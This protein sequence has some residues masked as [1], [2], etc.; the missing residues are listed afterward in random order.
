MS[1]TATAAVEV[2]CDPATAFAVFTADIASWWKRGTRYWN[3][4]ERARELRFEPGVGGRLIEV[5]DVATG[6]GFEIGRVLAWEPGK[7][8]AFTWRQGN[9]PD[10][11]FTEVEV[12]FEP[13]GDGTR[14]TIEHGG[15]ERVPSAGPGTAEG[16]GHGWDELLGFYHLRIQAAGA[17]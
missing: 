7:R 13:A 1:E 3:D 4:P 17:R 12:R 10:A 14:V 2:A 8:L 16:Y 5:Y 11:E 15:W 9:W 6:E